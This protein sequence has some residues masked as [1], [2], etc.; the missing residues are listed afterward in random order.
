MKKTLEIKIRALD[1]KFAP[2]LD[3]NIRRVFDFDWKLAPG[4]VIII[5][6]FSIGFQHFFLTIVHADY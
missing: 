2:E 5:I 3:D 6:I 1:W 4:F